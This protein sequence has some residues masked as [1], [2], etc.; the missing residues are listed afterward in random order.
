MGLALNSNQLFEISRTCLYGEKCIISILAASPFSLLKC[1][2]VGVQ[3]A[4][5]NRKWKAGDDGH[6]AQNVN[7]WLTFEYFS[8]NEGNK[9]HFF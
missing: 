4:A 1:R 8:Y 3:S 9:F 2:M 5:L 6:G 7:N